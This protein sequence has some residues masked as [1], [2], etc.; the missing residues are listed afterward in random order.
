MVKKKTHNLNDYFL[1]YWNM[2]YVPE[3]GL[4]W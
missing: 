2:F 4:S 1:I 3:Y